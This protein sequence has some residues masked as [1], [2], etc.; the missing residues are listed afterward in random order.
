MPPHPGPLPKGEGETQMQSA[1]PPPPTQSQFPCKSCGANL[2]FAPGTTSLQCPYCGA[3]NEIEPATGERGRA[4]EELDINQYFRD[5]CDEKDLTERITVKCTTCGAETTLAPNVTADRCPF[6]GSAIVAEG[7]SKKIIRPKSLLPFHIPR[8]QASQSFR[9]WI[10]GLWF[11]PNEL[12]R[13]A[14]AAE[15]NGVY[16]PAW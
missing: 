12:A 7:S 16:I 15:I 8:E 3:M 6:C 11:A 2:Q 4:I 13:R 10:A 14:E 5:C 9:H 1:S